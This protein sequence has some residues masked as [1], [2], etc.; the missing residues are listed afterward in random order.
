MG[1]SQRHIAEDFG[2]SDAITGVELTRL[3][4]GHHLAFFLT[5]DKA[6]MILHGDERSQLV[7]DSVVF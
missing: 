5:V 1:W 2:E 7:V 4:Q 6:V 3:E